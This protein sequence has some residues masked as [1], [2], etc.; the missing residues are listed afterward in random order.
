MRRAVCIGLFLLASVTAVAQN[1][2][3]DNKGKTALSLNPGTTKPKDSTQVDSLQFGI[4]LIKLSTS[5]KKLELNYYHYFRPD[6]KAPSFVGVSASGQIDNSVSSLLSSGDFATGATLNVKYG[7]RLFKRQI[8]NVDDWRADF[9]KKN[10]HD[11]TDADISAF[12]H[13]LSIASDFWLVMNAALTGS[14]FK[15]YA[16]DSAY[17]AQIQSKTFAAPEFNIGFNYWTA[18]VLGSTALIGV[19]IGVKKTNNFDDLTETTSDEVISNT[20]GTATR[21]LDAKAT[22]Y[23]GSYKETTSYPLNFDIYFKPHK[24]DNIAFLV[25]NHNELFDGAKSKSKVGAGLYILKKNDLFNPVFGINI[26]YADVADHY[27]ADEKKGFSRL[28]IGLVTN[29]DLLLFQ[30]KDK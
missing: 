30:K 14:K 26:D 22:V 25:Y 21:K 18:D 28:T 19:T 3:Q 1:I 2:I 6:H 10:G 20:S 12:V 23:T 17:A 11:P 8:V 16:P 13:H 7:L 29:L 5:E 24:F 15:L 4:G 9:K 27:L